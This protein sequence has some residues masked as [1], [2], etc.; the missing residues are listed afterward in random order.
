MGFYK[1]DTQNIKASD[2]TDLRGQ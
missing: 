2:G 1:L